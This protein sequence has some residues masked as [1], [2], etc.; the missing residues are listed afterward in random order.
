MLKIGLTGG[1][2]SG[3]SCVC[4]LFAELGAPIIDADLVA[5]QLVAP[6]QPAL[7]R[8]TEAFGDAVIN[9]DG[10]LNRAELRR[11]VFSEPRDKKRLDAIMHPL[12]YHEMQAEVARLRADYCIMAIPLLVETQHAYR[13]DRVLV[14]DCTL[15]T[16]VQRVVARDHVGLAQAEAIIANQATRQQRLAL[17]DDIIDNS[18]TVEYLA[19]QVKSLH[20]SYLL[21]A[22][23][24]TTSA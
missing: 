9:L 15:Q 2:G 11:R 7:T 10:S 4:G 19:E 18:T 22:T 21:L 16:Q 3:K 12:I 20:N 1:I 17:A 13:V 6:G 5:R 24:R 8:I 14:V 23:A